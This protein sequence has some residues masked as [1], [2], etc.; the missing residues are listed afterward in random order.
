MRRR[1]ARNRRLH[2]ADLSGGKDPFRAC[3]LE[4]TATDLARPEC[5]S[6]RPQAG[7]QSACCE[8]TTL[9]GRGDLFP[10]DGADPSV[11]EGGQVRKPIAF[12]M[13]RWLLGCWIAGVAT[14]AILPL[15]SASAL[16]A[17][18]WSI[19]SS[20]DVSQDDY[21]QAVTCA[22]AS[23]CWAVGYSWEGGDAYQTLIE[24]W[25]GSAWTIVSSPNTPD[26]TFNMLQSVT[27]ASVSE[28]WAVGY[29]NPSAAG[30]TLIEEWDGVAWSIVPSP[31]T[32]STQGNT[33]NGVT[34]ASTSDCWAVGEGDNT[35]AQT[36]IEH[37]DGS[38][39]SLISSPNLSSGANDYL[40]SV[41][42]ASTS[43]CWTVGVAVVRGVSQTLIEQWAGTK[44]AI[45][46]SPNSGTNVG[47]ALKD[48]T[49]ASAADCWAVGNYNPGGGTSQTLVERMTGGSWAI[50]STPVASGLGD[51]LECDRRDR[52]ANSSSGRAYLQAA[53]EGAWTDLV[54]R[55]QPRVPDSATDR[56]PG[57]QV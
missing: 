51:A 5:S 41:A 56:A 6:L 11:V 28:C 40:Q 54:R 15:T 14:A 13:S 23:Q 31:N 52:S 46:A 18:G 35:F 7:P 2:R 1:D 29:I 33:L 30:Q 55:R 43:V 50:V 10:M 9:L 4:V 21:L 3:G 24:E 8:V 26:G 48:V 32:S 42:C 45:V 47:N 16:A 20:P 22:T 34:C 17:S 57:P 37:W 49:C 12:K 27:C 36:L 38:K 44:W 19:I 25:S 53:E 39:W